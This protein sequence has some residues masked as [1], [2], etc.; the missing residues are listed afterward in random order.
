M[1]AGRGDRGVA[2]G[3]GT[4]AQRVDRAH[5]IQRASVQSDPMA[6]VMIAERIG[7]DDQLAIENDEVAPAELV[8]QWP[9]DHLTEFCT[10]RKRA[11]GRGTPWSA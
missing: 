3:H 9:D 5:C 7:A 6:G 10:L 2:I 8:E 4:D 1:A 11:Y